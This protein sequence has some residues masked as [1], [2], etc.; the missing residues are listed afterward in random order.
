MD[1]DENLITY[2][3]V[4][5]LT[6]ETQADDGE[7]SWEIIPFYGRTIQVSESL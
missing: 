7:C 6:T 4:N 3:W 5:F 1:L 2:I